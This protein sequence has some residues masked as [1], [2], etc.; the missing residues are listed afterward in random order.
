[1]NYRV[2]GPA[3]NSDLDTGDSTDTDNS[4]QFNPEEWVGTWITWTDEDGPVDFQV[5]HHDDTGF[6]GKDSEG[7]EWGPA[8]FD[9]IEAMDP[10]PE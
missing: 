10:Q 5:T 8:P 2:M 4:E 7:G 1:M 3:D 6:Y 9:R